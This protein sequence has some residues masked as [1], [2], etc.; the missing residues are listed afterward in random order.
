VVGADGFSLT[1]KSHRLIKIK[2]EFVSLDGNLATADG[3]PIFRDF[4]D[5]ILGDVFQTTPPQVSRED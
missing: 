3:R 2:T 1:C 5:L 4:R